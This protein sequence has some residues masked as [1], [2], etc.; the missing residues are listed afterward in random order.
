MACYFCVF[1]YRTFLFVCGTGQVD[2]LCS[3]L[4]R[5]KG[6][7]VMK[8]LKARGVG[9]TT[10]LGQ[11]WCKGLFL[12]GKACLYQNDN[13]E[14]VSYL[15]KGSKVRQTPYPVPAYSKNG[16]NFDIFV[17]FVVCSLSGM[18]VCLCLEIFIVRDEGKGKE[19]TWSWTG[20]THMLLVLWIEDQ[21]YTEIQCVFFVIV[22]VLLKNNWYISFLKQKTKITV[23]QNASAP[24]S[25]E[26]FSWNCPSCNSS[27]E[28]LLDPCGH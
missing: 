18:R 5:N 26:F 15:K 4:E 20:T 19:D 17:C 11:W 10:I 3:S 14:A 6:G 9:E 25:L 2:S 28:I 22:V 27:N 24:S 7:Q 16:D 1:V 21:F 12:G 8:A 13:E 23:V